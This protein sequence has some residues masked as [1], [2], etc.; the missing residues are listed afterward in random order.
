MDINGPVYVVIFSK[1]AKTYERLLDQVIAGYSQ[2]GKSTHSGKEE[3]PKGGFTLRMR[4]LVSC[5]NPGQ[6]HTRD[7]MKVTVL[8]RSDI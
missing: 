1:V 4:E 6:A 7:V 2:S 5:L 3:W 8:L